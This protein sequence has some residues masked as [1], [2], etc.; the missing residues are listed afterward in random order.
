VGWIFHYLTLPLYGL[1]QLIFHFIPFVITS[2]IILLFRL[3]SKLFGTLFRP[4]LWVFDRSFL[5]IE[6]TYLT[7]LKQ[8]L[9]GRLLVLGAV[10][11][12]SLASLLLLPKLGMELIPDMS[13]GEFFVE[14]TLPTGSQLENTDRV[15]ANLANFT[16][17]LEGVERTY[18]LAGT[19][20]L[21]NVSASQGGEY[22]GKLNVVMKAD[23]SALANQLVMDKMRSYLSK[24]AGV[25]SQF[26]KPSLFT[27]ATPLAVQI[28]GF[29]LANLAKYSQKMQDSMQGDN[30]F[31]DVKSS[32][33]STM[34][35]SPN[36]V[37]MHPMYLKSSPHKL[38][39]KW[40]PS[41]VLKIEK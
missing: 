27:F 3:L 7:G 20:S 31:A 8:A 36:W 41:S 4:I 11:A 37:S 14:I 24:Q 34:G 9:R 18:A 40:R 15:I 32:L 25:L 13:Q 19:G 35:N 33:N 12:V 10:I 38:V 21:M 1:V 2:L 6:K 23:S 16:A 17:G 29:D 5:Q 39:A 22:W 30:R 26:G 28:V